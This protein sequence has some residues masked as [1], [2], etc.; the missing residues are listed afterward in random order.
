MPEYPTNRLQGQNFHGSPMSSKVICTILESLAPGVKA[1]HVLE[2]W[3]SLPERGTLT[4]GRLRPVIVFGLQVEKELLQS[5]PG[6]PGEKAAS[7]QGVFY[8]SLP[9][10]EEGLFK[11]SDQAK[12][13]AIQPPHTPTIHTH[14]KII[15]L[16]RSFKHAC[17]NM[18]SALKAQAN[19]AKKMLLTEK[20]DKALASLDG[21]NDA[22]IARLSKEDAAIRFWVGNMEKIELEEIDRLMA[23]ITHLV[24][25]IRNVKKTRLTDAIEIAL[26]CAGAV[27]NMMHTLAQA[28]ERLD[29]V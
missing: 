3:G 25:D 29:H 1:M 14:P 26:K 7:E 12:Q 28:V 17:E 13:Y 23:E 5:M 18:K 21:F 6:Y 11:I 9:C 8:L 24:G 19:S 22:L 4:D 16:L 10:N 27:E 20:R 15:S 2:V